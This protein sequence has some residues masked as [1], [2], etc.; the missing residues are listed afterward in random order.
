MVLLVA[1][2]YEVKTVTDCHKSWDYPEIGKV[3][4]EHV[5]LQL[6]NHPDL[7][8]MIYTASSSTAEKLKQK[9]YS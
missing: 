8:V 6:S 2:C 1:I 7:K 3:E 4:F 9:I 5:D